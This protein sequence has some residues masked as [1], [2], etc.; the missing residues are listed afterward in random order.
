M[1]G[2]APAQP[3]D[4]RAHVFIL[5]RLGNTADRDDPRRRDRFDHDIHCGH[6]VL[7]FDQSKS[8]L[9]SCQPVG[10]RRD[11]ISQLTPAQPEHAAQLLRTRLVVKQVG[12]L[13]EST[14][15]DCKPDHEGA[16]RRRQR[17]GERTWNLWIWINSARRV[18]LVPV[19]AG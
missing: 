1:L 17:L 11:L 8:R 6:C 3:T 9:D 10:L 5:V 18:R 4:N 7:R 12:N 16:I 15:A 2:K 14:A 19:V 13:P